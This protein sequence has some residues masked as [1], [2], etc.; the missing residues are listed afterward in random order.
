MFKKKTLLTL[1]LSFFLFAPAINASEPV[2]PPIANNVEA[3]SSVQNI[4]VWTLRIGDRSENQALVQIKG[5]DH[6]WDN[7]IQKMDVEKTF[8]DV[9]YSTTLNGKPFVAI[10]LNQ[11]FAELHLPGEAGP[12]YIAFNSTLASEANADHFLTAYLEQEAIR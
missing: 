5:I 8:K 10:I 11:G 12:K 2:R 9:R 1:L 7:L 6:D 4:K 3:Y